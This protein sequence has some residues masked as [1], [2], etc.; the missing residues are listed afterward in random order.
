MMKKRLLLLSF[1]AMFT[2]SVVVIPNALAVGY[3]EDFFSGND[4]LFSDPDERVCDVSS[5]SAGMNLHGSNLPKETSDYLKN[6]G[7]DELIEKNKQRYLYAEQVS[8]VPWYVVAAL[9]YR[10]AGLSSSS[11]IFNGAPLGSGVNVDGQMVVSDAN[12]DAARAAKHLVSMGKGVY[13]VDITK[14][15]SFETLA[16]AFLAYNRGY[17]Y[18]NSGKTY[19]QSPYVMN[20][21]DQDH[22]NMNWPGGAGEPL[23]GIDGNKAGAM[24]A[25]AYFSGKTLGSTGCGSATAATGDLL[26][27]AKSLA[28]DKPVTN[29]TASKSQARPEYQQAMPQYNGSTGADAW[30]DCGVFVSTVMHMSGADKDFPQRGTGAMINYVK[31]STKY[32]VI[33]NPQMS[34]LM[35]GDLLIVNTS[36]IGHIM[37]YGGNM[38]RTSDGSTLVVVDAS[39]NQ[40][41]PSLRTTG[42]LQFMLNKS[43]VVAARLV[44]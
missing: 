23:S 2:C 30:S 8:K 38:G 20:G 40:R 29:G 11:S 15:Q 36:E 9:H 13:G 35:P 34:D 6:R 25:A 24:A 3:D 44:K 19:L 39:L 32:K 1:I 16:K 28:W 7:V 43:G 5:A 31:K 42:D 27:T 10:E 12:E 33:E 14:D 41:V 37:I 17:L 21:Y 26:E 4:I 22:M 18:K